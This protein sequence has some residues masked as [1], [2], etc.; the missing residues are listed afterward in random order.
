[1]QSLGSRALMLVPVRRGDETIG[2]ILLEDARNSDGAREFLG[3]VAAILASTL[4]EAGIS[5]QP[6]KVARIEAVKERS[7]RPILSADLRP[8]TVERANLKSDH[9]SEVAVMALLLSGSLELAKKCG[10]ADVGM[11]AQI[12]EFLQ[13]IAAEYG[14]T[15]V[16]FVGQEAIAAAGFEPSDEDPMASVASLAIA[17]RDRLSHLIDT[18][19]HAAEFRIGLGFGEGYGCLVGRE[20]AHFNLWGQA[21]EV[22][23]TMARSA[24]PG[25]IQASAAAYAQLRQDFLFRP[26]GTF[27][28][29]GVGQ[30]HTIVL[31][32]QL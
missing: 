2:G 16:K 4:K 6:T 31:A 1:M 11:A 18:S 25:A 19:G 13:E 30:S 23:G 22:A 28:Q 20:R 3:T 27:Y 5:E 10:A 24:Q 15:Y 29:P 17:V 14:V 7:S 26:R 9:F 32:G 12:T 21:F 8:S